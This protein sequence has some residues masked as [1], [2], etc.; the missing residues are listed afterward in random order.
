LSFIVVFLFTNNINK[1]ILIFL[2]LCNMRTKE[3]DGKKMASDRDLFYVLTRQSIGVPR[4]NQETSQPYR[5]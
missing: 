4:K 5:Q 2:L 1:V 3:D